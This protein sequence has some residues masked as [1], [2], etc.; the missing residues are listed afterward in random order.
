MAINIK[1]DPILNKLRES[2]ESGSGTGLLGREQ[3]V[4]TANQK[5]FT[6][7]SVVLTSSYT[8]FTDDNLRPYGHTRVGQV[9]TFAVG[10]PLGTT[11]NIIN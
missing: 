11:V 1:F 9:V 10:L 6:C 2:D 8:V 4:A 3:F 5:I 7:T